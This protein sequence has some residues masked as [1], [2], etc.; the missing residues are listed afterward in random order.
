MV[1]VLNIRNDPIS[2]A[3]QKHVPLFLNI[4]DKIYEKRDKRRGNSLQ[5]PI[6]QREQGMD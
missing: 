6:G 3:G 2:Y 5:V 1:Y 4:R